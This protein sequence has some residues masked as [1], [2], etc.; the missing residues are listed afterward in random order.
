MKFVLLLALGTLMLEVVIAVA[1]RD[2]G[3]FE[4]VL[5]VGVGLFLVAAAGRV[6][7]IGIRRQVV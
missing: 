4:K 1:T 7:Q 5:L 6:W 2:T 3:V